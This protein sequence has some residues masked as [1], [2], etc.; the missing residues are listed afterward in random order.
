MTTFLQRFKRASRYFMKQMK[1]ESFET[2]F[3]AQA[4]SPR[5]SAAL[6]AVNIV[7]HCL[8]DPFRLKHIIQSWVIFS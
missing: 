6:S 1:V 7:L 2:V 5:V 3:H 4:E 8:F